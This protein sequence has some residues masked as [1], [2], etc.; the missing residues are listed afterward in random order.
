M[1]GR[2]VSRWARVYMDGYDVSGYARSIGALD[3]TFD[4]ANLTAISDSIKGYLPAMCN[5]SPSSINANLDNTAGGL[6]ETFALPGSRI[7]T[8]ALG[9]RATPTAGDPVY[10]G[11]FQQKDYLAS[12]DAGAMVVNMNFDGWD[13]ANPA[14]YDCPWGILAHA[15]GAETAVNSAT[16]VDGLAA[17]AFGGYMVYQVLAGNGTATLK[18]Q[19]AATNLNASFADLSGATSGVIDCTTPKAGLIALSRTATVRQFTRWQIVLGTA[20]T[21]TFA[22]AFVRGIH[23]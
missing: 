16:G 15:A 8:I 3:W 10:V 2:T 6:H 4:E 14:V 22:L 17:S 12:E 19:D 18:M 5:I 7:V 9:I 20:T 21:V 23:A 11:R 13:A 1:S